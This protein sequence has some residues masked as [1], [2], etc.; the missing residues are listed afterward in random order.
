M[1]EVVIK[2]SKKQNL[3]YAA[4]GI[5][6]SFMSIRLFLNGLS[7]SKLVYMIIGVL[8]L[9]LSFRGIIKNIYKA[10]ET[11]TLLVI[12]ENGITDV[13]G[14][15]GVGFIG[16]QD[17]K[18]IYSYYPKGKKYIGIEVFE[19]EKVMNRIST[20]EQKHIQDNLRRDYPPISI[21]IHKANKSIEKI[22]EIMQNEM[23]MYN[24]KFKKENIKVKKKNA[25]LQYKYKKAIS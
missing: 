1:K 25:N 12:S 20:I 22:L 8:F 3:I 11:K 14:V 24:I 16:W 7:K 4:I 23:R 13:G 5:A 19:L 2:K 18:K 9:L 10:Y 15:C 17:I 21:K 6:V